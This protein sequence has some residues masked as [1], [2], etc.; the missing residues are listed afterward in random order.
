MNKYIL[1]LFVIGLLACSGEK[2]PAEGAEDEIIEPEITEENI[3]DS[4]A[5]ETLP[6][7]RRISSGQI[8]GVEVTINYGSPGVKGREIWGNLEPWNEVWRAGAN[9]NT[10]I[11]FSQ[12]VLVNSTPLGSGKYGF[13]MIP[14]VEG[15]WVIIFSEKNDSWGAYD[16]NTEEDALRVEIQPEMNGEIAER[17]QYEV[18]PSSID[19]AWEKVRIKI[20]IEGDTE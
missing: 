20:E 15:P 5:N 18:N 14:R 19:F 8:D 7:P 9:E 17:L 11:T 12:D 1:F 4:E 13:F 16:Y 6:S 3:I 2:K 10:T